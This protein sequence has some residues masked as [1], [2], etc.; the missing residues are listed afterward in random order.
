MYPICDR[1]KEINHGR[2]T[3]ISICD[4]SREYYDVSDSERPLLV[5][6]YEERD[7]RVRV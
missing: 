6:R 4:A 7:S 1:V 2:D 5:E 3:L